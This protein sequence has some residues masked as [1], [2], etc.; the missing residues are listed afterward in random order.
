M[1]RTQVTNC[2][3]RALTVAVSNLP[4]LETVMAG[5]TEMVEIVGE[6]YEAYVKVT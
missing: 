3:Q 6:L 2:V 1:N 5:S 4:N